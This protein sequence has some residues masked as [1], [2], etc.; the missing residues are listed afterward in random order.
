MSYASGTF[1]ERALQL[2]LAGLL[3]KGYAL[4]I[5]WGVILV[6]PQKGVAQ[7]GCQLIPVSSCPANQASCVAGSCGG[8]N[9]SCS[10][11]GTCS[12]ETTNMCGD[13]ANDCALR[14]G[15]CNAS[16]TCM[17]PTNCAVGA[18]TQ[19]CSVSLPCCDLNATCRVATGECLGGTAIRLRSFTA[20]AQTDGT[21]TLVWETAT[22]VDNAGFNLYRTTTEGGPYTKINRALI[23]AQG[24]PVAGASYNYVDSPGP[25]TFR[26]ILTDVDIFGEI[27]LHGP[28]PKDIKIPIR[29]RSP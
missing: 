24:N 1:F 23:P 6:T 12:T 13:V 16:C 5:I 2:N 28:V 4:V 29:Q 21:V 14:G 11:I 26:Y 18:P 19:A 27:T 17:I 9:C 8:A 20:E 15:R 25:G 3:S 22:E 7:L 10:G